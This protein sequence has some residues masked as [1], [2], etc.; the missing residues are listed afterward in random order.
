MMLW[1]TRI[2]RLESKENYMEMPKSIKLFEQLFL[3]SLALGVI[4]GALMSSEMGLSGGLFLAGWMALV[5]LIVGTLVLLTSRKKSLI[6]KWIT[7]VYVVLGILYFALL[8]NPQGLS[9]MLVISFVGFLMQA[10]AIYLLFKA[11]SK[12]WFASKK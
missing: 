7:T 10:Y 6:C 11:D 2:V 4:Q 8:F 1:L 3:G 5:M 9:L 12:A